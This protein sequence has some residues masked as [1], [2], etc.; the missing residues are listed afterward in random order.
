MK[1]FNEKI[2]DIPRTALYIRVSTD[3]QALHGLSL[4][5]QQEALEKWAHDNG[6]KI[7]DRY[8]DGGKTAR[9]SIKSRTELQRLIKDVEEDKI[10]LIIFTKLDRW[11]RNIKDYYKVQEILEKHNV[12]WKTIFE[13]YDTTTANGRLHINI[14]L[15]IAQDEADRTSE[16]IKAVFESKRA[17]GEAVSPSLP[18]GYRLVNNHIEI[19]E[20]R[21]QIAIDLFEHYYI[22]QKQSAVS[23]YITDIHGVHLEPW[24]IRRALKNEL[25]IGTYHGIENFCEPLIDRQRFDEIQKIL[26]SKNVKKTPSNY[27]Y[28]FSGLLRCRECGHKMYGNVQRRK[29]KDNTQYLYVTYRCNRYYNH[30]VCSHGRSINE[31][32]IEEYL[33]QNIKNAI[34]DFI[35][36]FETKQAKKVNLGANKSEIKQKLERLKN[37]YVNG[38]I[39]MDEYKKDYEELNNKLS[40]AE[41]AEPEQDTSELKAFLESDILEKYYTLNNKSRRIMWRGVIGRLVIDAD[42]N[43]EIEFTK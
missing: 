30:K 38:F 28:I 41:S 14:M 9:K 39:G 17:R 22:H 25:Y 31:K 16:R 5:A 33:L 32:K 19:D 6:C 27:D 35:Y 23:E 29:N 13:N 42:N 3:E 4:E 7:A 15:S 18:I 26:E 43:I 8:I 11:F 20:E 24:V 2:N 1:N 34:N 12:N 36:Q 10:D 37:L 21:A 40:A